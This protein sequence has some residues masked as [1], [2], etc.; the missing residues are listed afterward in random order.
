MKK[1]LNEY[2]QDMDSLHYTQEQKNQLASAA[3]HAAELEEQQHNRMHRPVR[4]MVLVIAA[5]LAI[6]IGTASATGTLK[7]LAEIFSPVLGSSEDQIEIMG[8]MGQPIGVSDTDNG[9]T[10]TADGVIGD[11][12]NA[13]IVYTISWDEENTIPL[14]DN[15][16][17][18]ADTYMMFEFDDINLRDT[19]GS[20]FGTAWFTDNDPTDNAIQYCRTISGDAELLLGKVT[21][22]FENLQY[23]STDISEPDTIFEGDWELEFN[24]NYTNSAV[25]LDKEQTFSYDGLEGAIVTVKNVTVS[26]LGIH[27]EFELPSD[28]WENSYKKSY[29]VD[30]KLNEIPVTLT[31]TDGT[32][33]ELTDK[34]GFGLFI[35]RSDGLTERIMGKGG[36]FDEIIPLDDMAT[37]TIG[38]I[39]YDIP[40]N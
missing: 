21:A 12:Y 35:W 17:Q 15:W 18:N 28:I 8:A 29:S 22:T 37:L 36:T 10:I 25:S 19:Q 6:L 23:R 3:I 16:Q 39:T 33:L 14:P 5:A 38:D 26:P 2:L 30:D 9:I 20:S 27:A 13:C 31:K 40:H 4:R 24:V 1:R 32:V 11:K 7:N 34:C